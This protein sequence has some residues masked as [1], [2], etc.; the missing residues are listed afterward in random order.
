MLN[1]SGAVPAISHLFSPDNDDR[2][3]RKFDGD[4]DHELRVIEEL[5]YHS[6]NE[7]RYISEHSYRTNRRRY[8]RQQRGYP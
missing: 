6:I 7:P 2:Y 3:R 1:S 4:F 8:N 5:H